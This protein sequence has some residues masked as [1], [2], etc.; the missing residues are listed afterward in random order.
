MICFTLLVISLFLLTVCAAFKHP[1]AFFTQMTQ[2]QESSYLVQVSEDERRNM[3]EMRARNLKQV[4][5][6][7]IDSDQRILDNK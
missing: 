7:N 5:R 2:E 1:E 4:K 6:L 3:I